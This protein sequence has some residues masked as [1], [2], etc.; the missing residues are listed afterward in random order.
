M[1]LVTM[2]LDV[3]SQLFEFFYLNNFLNPV[4][5]AIAAVQDTDLPLSS[6]LLDKQ[7][8]LKCRKACQ[9][10]YVQWNPCGIMVFATSS[11][12]PEIPLQNDYFFRTRHCM[13]WSAVT[14]S[15]TNSSIPSNLALTC[16]IKLWYSP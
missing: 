6:Q 10:D 5:F 15:W 9:T 2:K 14:S 1:R 13:P 7:N 11:K 4:V 16:I 8:N 3:N 12:A